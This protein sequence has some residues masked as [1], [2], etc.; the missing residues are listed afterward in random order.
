[1][2]REP[3]GLV[4]RVRAGRDWTGE[5]TRAIDSHMGAVSPDGRWLVAWA[6]LGGDGAPAWQAF[7]LGGGAPV[8]IGSATFFDWAPDGSA[9]SVTS[10]FGGADSRGPEL[11]HPAAAR[12]GFATSPG[13]RISYRRGNRP[14][15]GSAQDRCRC[16]YA[17]SLAGRLRV[18][19]RDGPAQPVPDPDSVIRLACYL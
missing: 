3:S 15:A 12:P 6:A 18:L 1:M 19:S 13:R 5:G 9:V 4:Y 10:E 16:R 14:P 11:Y 7:P 17:R 2:Q 8:T